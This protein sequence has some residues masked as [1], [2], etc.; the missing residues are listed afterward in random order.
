MAGGSS[1]KLLIS[2]RREAWV[3]LAAWLAAMVYSVGYCYLH[4]YQRTPENLTFV[5]GMP[6]WIFWGVAIPW[7]GCFL[8]SVWFAM[9][10]MQD[11]PM[12]DD[13]P[14]SPEADRG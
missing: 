3:A 13:E 8:F 14:S 10:F 4:G 1:K 12:D 11:A 7:V 9:G 6:D 2:G 5:L